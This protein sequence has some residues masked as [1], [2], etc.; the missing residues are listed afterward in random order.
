MFLQVYLAQKGLHTVVFFQ[1]I[2]HFNPL[3]G[4]ICFIW[5][6]E[7]PG[8]PELQLPLENKEKAKERVCVLCLK[9]QEPN[10][11]GPKSLPLVFPT[12][13]LSEALS[14]LGKANIYV[15]PVFPVGL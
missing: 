1:G 7:H 11:P 9:D 10:K 8:L 4:H 12:R 15:S 2:L 5:S 13:E 3:L 6:N 14:F